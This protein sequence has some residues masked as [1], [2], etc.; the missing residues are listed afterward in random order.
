MFKSPNFL[1]I[2]S[3]LVLHLGQPAIDSFLPLL[4]FD[5]FF[6]TLGDMFG[7]L[8]FLELEDLN[9]LVFFAELLLDVVYMFFQL[10]VFEFELVGIVE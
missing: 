3:H 7:Q 8:I 1:R 2:D 5:D 9:L 6:L 10:L 4:S